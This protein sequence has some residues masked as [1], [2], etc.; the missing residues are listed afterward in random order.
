MSQQPPT[1][2]MREN[3][4]LDQLKRQAKEL[5]DAWRASSPEAIVEV[6]AYHRIASPE[7]SRCTTLSSCWRARTASKAGRS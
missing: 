5:L 2:A 3:P 1:R 6:T 4:D 7:P